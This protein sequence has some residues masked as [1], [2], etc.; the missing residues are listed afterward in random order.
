VVLLAGFS[1]LWF[2]VNG[3]V[4]GVVLAPCDGAGGLAVFRGP[5][6]R[7]AQEAVG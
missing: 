2:L 6:W 3:S 7:R 4:E 5:A 1:L